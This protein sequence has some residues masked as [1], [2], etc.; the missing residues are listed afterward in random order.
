MKVASKRD[1]AFAAAASVSSVSLGTRSTL[2]RTSTLAVLTSPSLSKIASASSSKPL[3]ASII[4]P[5]RSASWAPLQAVVTIARSSRRRGA[6]MPGVSTKM[7]CDGPSLAM[8][9]MSDRVVWTLR[10]TMVTF[11]PTNALIN[12]DLPALG[13]PIRATKPQRASEPVSSTIQ[14]VHR[15]ANPLQHGGSGV[16]FGRALGTAQALGRRPIRQH[17]RYAEFGIVMRSG[18]REFAIGRRRQAARLRPFLQHGLGI[19]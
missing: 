13:A 18:A 5:A 9:R 17:H 3:R 16:L 11:E 8:P 2:L 6:K 4:T 19:A 10:E 1:F 12:V 14:L 15:D 7:S